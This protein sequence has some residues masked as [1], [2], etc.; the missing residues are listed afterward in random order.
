V[1][2]Y[3]L[4]MVGTKG[5]HPSESQLI[6]SKKLTSLIENE[7]VTVVNLAKASGLGRRNIYDAI[8]CD[9]ATQLNSLDKIARALAV[10][11]WTLLHP[12]TD[13]EVL[14]FITIFNST[15]EVGKEIIRSAVA[16]AQRRIGGQ[17]D[18]ADK[19]DK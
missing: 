19:G 15:D 12:V 6:L 4:E 2:E 13:S 3:K 9:H 10:K 8:N 14:K 16:G 11:A 1:S 18:S 7:G 17:D 5:N